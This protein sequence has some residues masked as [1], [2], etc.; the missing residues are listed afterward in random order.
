M[1][2]VGPNGKKVMLMSDV[3]GTGAGT[4]AVATNVTLTFDAAAAS[5]LP[6]GTTTKIVTGTYLPTNNSA[7]T[8]TTDSFPAPSLPDPAALTAAPY[9]PTGL[10]EFNGA[11]PNGTW[12]L[13]VVDDA[14]GDTGQIAGGYSLTITTGTVTPPVNVAPTVS[15]AAVPPITLPNSAALNGTV[16]DDGLPTA[17]V[18][19]AWTKI[20][21]P[22]TVTF[23]NAN[24]VDTTA[25]FSLA[26]T[27]VLRLTATDSQPLSNFAEVTVIVNPQVTPVNVAPT[28]SIAAVSP[29]TLP[30]S[31]ALNG[32]VTDDGLPTATVTTA[33]STI[34]GPGTVTFGAVSAV[35]T[36]ATFS[37][38]GTYVLRLTANDS[39]PLSNFA[40]VTVTV[41]PQV[42]PPTGSTQTFTNAAAIAINASG[43]CCDLSG[44]P[45]PSAAFLSGASSAKWS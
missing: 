15:I 12:K 20:S 6:P 30:N 29:I 39:Q 38:A 32:T 40:E 43:A 3:G 17:T 13:F 10:T 27:Y 44:E 42:T 18:T 11:S 4:T 14:T 33:W 31:A 35:D 21:G 22:G 28:V 2:L 7:G 23:G 9:T 37:A 24:L 19:T 1:L 41:N 45:S 25:S 5:A 8:P 34:S 26:G 36:T 16:T